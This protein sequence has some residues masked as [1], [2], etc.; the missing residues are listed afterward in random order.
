LPVADW[1]AELDAKLEDAERMESKMNEMRNGG[2]NVGTVFGA[3]EWA[4]ARRKHAEKKAG[5]K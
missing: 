4:E 1:W 3:D 5:R 2:K